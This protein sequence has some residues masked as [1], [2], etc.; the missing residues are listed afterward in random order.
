MTRALMSLI[1]DLRAM[2]LSFQ[3]TFNFVSAAMA[4]AILFTI[5]GFEPWSL[6][7]EPRY[8]NDFTFS[9]LVPWT[10]IPL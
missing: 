2:F 10:P 8:S 7:I 9:S 5:S 6:I 4:W 3:I 1:L